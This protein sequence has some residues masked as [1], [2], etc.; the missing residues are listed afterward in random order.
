[1]HELGK[2]T[3]DA[4]RARA[5]D[6]SA[7]GEAVPPLI[8]GRFRV[9]RIL[10]EGSFG[11]VCLAHD[12]QLTRWVAIKI[13]H[14]HLV[15]QPA[16]A[17]LYLTEARTVAG[18]DHPHIV[19]V[20]DVGS[21]TDF[22]VFVVSKFIDGSDL[23]KRMQMVPLVLR[24]AVELIA[25]VADALHH[26]HKQGLV[27]RD[28]KPANLLLDKSGKV[29]V[30]DFGMALREQ[31]IGKGP[32]FAGT[33]AYMSPE[34]ARGEGHR[35]DGRSDIFSLGVVFYQLLTGKYPF[36]GNNRDEYLEQIIGVEARPPRQ[37]DDRVPKE[38]D[39]ICLK[40]MAKR[41]SERYSTARDLADDLRN[42][43]ATAPVEEITSSI[44]MLRSDVAVAPALID[45]RVSS[46]VQPVK[47]VPKGLRSFDATD[48][49]FFIEL[50]PGPRG[51]EGLP[52]SLRFWK[53]RIETTNADS[54]FTVGLLYGPSGCGKSSLVKAGL[55][56]KLASTVLV[57]QIDATALETEARLLKGLHRLVPSLSANLSLVESLTEVRR[58]RHLQPR[59]KVL[60]VLDQFEQWLHAARDEENSELVRALRQCD[61]DR[62]QC[63]VLVRD[64][65]G[66][67][68]TRFMAALDIP[69]AQGV[70]FATVDLF[71]PLHARKVLAAFGCAYGRLPDNLGRCSKEQDAFL[72]QAVADLAEDGKV[73]SV[74]LALFAEM[75]KGKPWTPATLREVGGT[76]GVGVTFLEETFTAAGAPP[77]HRLHQKAAQ[78]VLK[79]LLPEAGTDIKGHMRSRQELLAASG[80]AGRP[81]DFDELMR[82]LDAEL[83]LLTP[84]DP[85]GRDGVDTASERGGEKYYQ[86]AHDYLVPSLRE[87]LTRKQKE[88][89]RGRAELLLADRA[90]IWGV[91]PEN[92]QLPSL[93]QWL[94]ILWLT[95][96]RNWT[97]AQ[98]RMMRRATQ[99]HLVAGAS[100]GLLTI[101][102]AVVSLALRRQVVDQQDVTHAAGLVQAV[103]NAETAQVPGVVDGMAEYRRWT[104]PLLQA[105]YQK[106]AETSRQKL[107]A[108]LALLPTDPA[109][110]DYL[111]GRLLDASP[112]EVPVIREA[113]APH[114]SALQ[115]RLWSVAERPDAGKESRRLRAA[116][117]L[118]HYDPDDARWDGVGKQVASDLVLENPIF[119]G[120]WSEALRPVKSW[121]IPQLSEIFR[122]PRPERLTERGLAA[123]LLA[124]YAADRPAVLAELVKDADEKQFA[125]IFPV[126]AERQGQALPALM[127]ELN[128]S[129]PLTASEDEREKAAKRK[130]NAAVA[131][132]RLN[133]P[134]SV[135][136]LLQQSPDPRVRSYLVHRLGPLGADPSTVIHRL[137]QDSNPASRRS[138]VLSLGEYGDKQLSASAR[139]EVLPAL[140]ETYKTSPDPGLHAA[141]EWLLRTRGQAAWLNQT[142]GEWAQGKPQREQRLRQICEALATEK[143]K[144]PPT[145]YV[146]GRGQT[147]VVIPGPVTFLMGSPESE[148]GRS[149]GETQHR[150]RIGRSFCV[151]AKPVTAEQFTKFD[152]TYQLPPGSPRAADLPAVS[153]TWFQAAAYCNWLSKEEGIPEAQWCYETD[154]KGEVVKLKAKYL[155]LAGYRLPTEAEVEY[156]TRAGTTCSRCFG[157][158]DELLPKYAW[159]A[160]N[161]NERLWPAGLLKPNDLGLFDAHGN[162]WTWC[163]EGSQEYPK[164]DSTGVSEDREDELEVVSTRS[165]VLRGGSYY[166]Q[167]SNSRSAYRDDDMPTYRIGRVSFRVARTLAP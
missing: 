150:K 69:I 40:C 77:Q 54:T 97:A 117:A 92:R 33:P 163:Q 59:Q 29:F 79:A 53:S 11:I 20:Y 114:G 149:E 47:I 127:A 158:S 103:L 46:E 81:R 95:S 99:Y 42:F 30:G 162:V 60:L 80:Y 66:M 3:D 25:A 124:D 102:V 104:D 125:V 14:P 78:A 38:L 68:A 100:F 145:W 84:T 101:V 64:D 154:A 85:E 17:E 134:E 76:E 116:S 72:D 112:S 155:S 106:A 24:E 110:V 18:L 140:Q 88:T 13:P 164:G 74:R 58:G 34:Q 23:A 119:L 6:G 90:A 167:S 45:T 107:H 135:W 28:I 118:A 157:E 153:V 131:L 148:A 108:S 83:R 161:S 122:D 71:D 120:Q 129:L 137:E 91:R 19:S 130:A 141:V 55:L 43:L 8:V 144:A 159:F 93:A 48:A 143:E 133:H 142:N 12:D 109:Q 147:M 31:D 73:I 61:G 51:R 15:A 98:Q 128:G 2:T 22:P 5:P 67:A 4:S 63:I 16:D 123:N 138:L 126:M 70:N 151:S 139:E 27:H 82:I 57:L 36:K 113:L 21:T 115:E 7:V 9:E 49:D 105:E 160:K 86:L 166:N 96:R 75:V 35:V 121:L 132:L 156:A 94:Q 165:R 136:P 44:F 26:A 50:L 41:A 62:L 111:Y 146:T 39:R 1:V 52:D 37:V 10:G 89:K 56:P 152:R 32:R 87:W 65:F